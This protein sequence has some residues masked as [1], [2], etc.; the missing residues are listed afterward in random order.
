MA[1][2]STL[3]ANAKTT[4]G[5]ADPDAGK[6][7][8]GKNTEDSQN[9]KSFDPSE[10]SDAE[11]SKVLED[12][13][14]WGHSRIKQIQERAKLADKLEKE[15]QEAEEAKLKE[16]GKLKELLEK[17]E[18]ELEELQKQLT[19]QKVDMAIQAEAT[20]AGVADVDAALKLV[21]R[22][23]ITAEE[24]EVKG[25][26]EAIKSLTENR[27][28]LVGKAS[29]TKV[30]TGSAPGDDTTN[31]P[32]KFKASQLQ[33]PKFYRENRDDIQVALRQ[34]LIEDDLPNP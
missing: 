6:D 25:V 17:R 5:G 13:R 2:D 20:K 32:K 21:D 11:L 23:G 12:K 28:Y 4:E 33:D 27:P 15:K 3:K 29:S 19:G 14:L 34:G 22:S 26:A 8:D 9:G 1:D 18:S 16:E 24:G 30:G 7:K 31:T 10:L